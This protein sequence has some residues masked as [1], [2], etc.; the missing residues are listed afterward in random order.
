AYQRDKTNNLAPPELKAIH[1]LGKSP[2]LE[3]DGVVITESGAISEHLTEKYGNGKLMPPRDSQ[4][5]IAYRQWMHFAEGSAM[6]P[7]LLLLF[8]RVDGAKM[9]FLPAYAQA[10]MH[11]ILTYL[12]DSVGQTGYLVGDA[13]TAADILNSFLLENVYNSS[14]LDNYP[15]LKAYIEKLMTLPNAIKAQ[16]LEEK[17]S[18]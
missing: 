16:E 12:N 6:L 15:E 18:S 1:P 9:N 5:F 17:Y 14:G 10:E 2:V 3:D 8:I 11:K 13:L 4:A 7:A